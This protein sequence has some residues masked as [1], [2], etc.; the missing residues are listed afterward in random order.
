M[1]VACTMA[2]GLGHAL[3]KALDIL[4]AQKMSYAEMIIA[5]AID[6]EFEGLWYTLHNFD[7]AYFYVNYDSNKSIPF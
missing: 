4:V 5:N 7:G 1:R 3:V 2:V 6:I